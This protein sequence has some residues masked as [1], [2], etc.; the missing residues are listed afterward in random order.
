MSEDELYSKNGVMACDIKSNESL[1]NIIGMSQSI[2][3]YCAIKTTEIV[4]S[5][6]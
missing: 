6:L 1:Y 3:Q 2:L 5:Y 4:Q